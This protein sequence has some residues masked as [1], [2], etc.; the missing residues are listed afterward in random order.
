MFLVYQL[1]QIQKRH[2]ILIKLRQFNLKLRHLDHISATTR[3][4]ILVL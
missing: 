3:L 4:I 1:K 2:L